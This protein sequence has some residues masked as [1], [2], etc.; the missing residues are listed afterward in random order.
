MCTFFQF[1]KVCC[2]MLVHLNYRYKKHSH[3][4]D[5]S[6]KT[7]EEK[8]AILGAASGFPS[9]PVVAAISSADSDDADEGSEKLAKKA[10]KKEKK[11][12]KRKRGDD[13]DTEDA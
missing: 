5:F 11:V 6:A 2:A 13:S 9:F 7:D 4:K 10:R 3:A 1:L 8:R 12:K